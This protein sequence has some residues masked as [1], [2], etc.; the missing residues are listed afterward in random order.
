[1]HLNSTY[2]STY[3]MYLILKFGICKK[4]KPNPSRVFARR[5]GIF[6]YST[7]YANKDKHKKLNIKSVA[8]YTRK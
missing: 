5:P 1:M 8:Q 7:A 6:M 3:I 4:P 2:T